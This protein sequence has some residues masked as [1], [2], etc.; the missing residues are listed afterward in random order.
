MRFLS[1]VLL[2]FLSFS[3]L[4]VVEELRI[5]IGTYD[6]PVGSPAGSGRRNALTAFNED[7]GREICR[8]INARCRVTHISFGEMLPGIEAKKFDLGFGNFLRTPEREARVAFSDPIWRS[9]SRLV[10]TPATA[11]RFVAEQ[12]K[13]VALD[14]LRN[15]RIV[16]LPETQQYR[17]LQGRASRDGLTLVAASSQVEAFALLRQG[18]ADFFLL[19]MVFAYVQLGRE[20]AGSF[21]F[22]GAPVI[23]G[24]LGGSVHIIL[25]KADESLRDAVNKAIAALRADGTYHRIVRQHFPFSLE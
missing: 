18:K 14:G 16:V 23:E 19:P 6:E 5:A 20:E 13:E 25:P 7:L 1:F 12:G 3:S 11:R 17:Y 24:G 9:S 8:R 22:F 21:E 10:T 2:L 15:A 4:A